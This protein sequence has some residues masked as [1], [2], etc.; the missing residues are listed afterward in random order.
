MK[1][2]KCERCGYEWETKSK[3]NYITCPNCLYKTHAQP[4]SLPCVGV[5][6]GFHAQRTRRGEGLEK[7]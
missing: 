4:L 6:E 2:V 3:L 1:K 7:K 5:A